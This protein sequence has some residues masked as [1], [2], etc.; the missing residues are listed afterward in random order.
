MLVGV[1]VGVIVG[2]LVFVGVIEGVGKGQVPS[3]T[4]FNVKKVFT[5][6]F[7]LAHTITLLNLGM[8]NN[9]TLP[10]QSVYSVV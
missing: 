1:I 4:T 3:N 5:T 7:C 10:A 9:I 2:V 6:L 8:V